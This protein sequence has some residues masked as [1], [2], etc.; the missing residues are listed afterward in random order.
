MKTVLSEK[1]RLTRTL[2]E[3]EVE[4]SPVVCPG[5]MMNSAIVDIMADTDHA[6]PDAH[7]DWR[8]MSALAEDVYLQTGFE[9]IG[10]PFCMTVEAEALGS[11]I[12][13]G[14]AEC[15]PKIAKEV[16][17]N[18]QEV[19]YLPK[20][21]ILK[22]SRTATVLDTVNN[23]SKKFINTPVIGS[24]TGPI[25][26]AASLVDP[27]TFL[28][29]L[30]KTP[31]DAHKFL[32]YVTAELIGYAYELI[33][34]GASAIAI[35][36]PTATGEILGPRLFGNF[37]LEYLN[38]L[39]DAIRS[40][41]IPVIVHICGDVTAVLKPISE[42]HTNALSVDA[43]VNLRTLKEKIPDF[44]TM[45]N[46]STYLLQFSTPDKV[47]QNVERVSEDADIIAPACGLSTTT[48]LENIQA[49]T[50][51]AKELAV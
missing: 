3:E 21:A 17:P 42:L 20:G 25:S 41:N 31:A 48:P 9:N 44:T 6:F 11:E 32:D 7:T 19:E 13:L 12:N 49:L 23:L 50:K 2:N 5:G 29:Q 46:I 8:I 38:K 34:N 16:F 10:V 36:D 4:R 15:E 35:C 39:T 26:T 14:N 47:A 37:A 45:G 22:S 30:Y 18:L 40:A 1:E 28:K 27:M 43:M 51:S 24:L 33:S